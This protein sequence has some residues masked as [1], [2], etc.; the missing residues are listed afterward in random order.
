MSNTGR[1]AQGDA[2]T[3]DIVGRDKLTAGGDIVGRDLHIAG[4][5]IILNKTTHIHRHFRRQRPITTLAFSLLIISTV[6]VLT[7]AGMIIINLVPTVPSLL[8]SIQQTTQQPTNTPLWHATRQPTTTA[9]PTSIGLP[10][11]T[12]LPPTPSF[13]CRTY[14]VKPGDWLWKIARECG[15]SPQSIAEANHLTD[16]LLTVGQVLI[17][18]ASYTSTYSHP[19]TGTGQATHVVQAGETLY[20]IARRYN[21]T[22]QAIAAANGIANVNL[23]PPGTVL[24]IP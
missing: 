18:P 21:R 20:S 6:A 1:D 23:V 17:I 4:H 15:V 24:V 3:G 7:A 5:D 16:Q 19:E 10:I 14:V 22:V 11:S 9:F 12:P 2:S 8:T 13:A